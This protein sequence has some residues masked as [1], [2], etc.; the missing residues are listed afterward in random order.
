MRLTGR[1]HQ[2][3]VALDEGGSQTARE[4]S[5]ETPYPRHGISLDLVHLRQLGLVRDARKEDA[6]EITPMGKQAMGNG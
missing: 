5:E 6:W 2:I 1:E 3:L 4:L